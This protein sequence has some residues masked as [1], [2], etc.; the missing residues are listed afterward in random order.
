VTLIARQNGLVP[1]KFNRLKAIQAVAFLLKQKH[2]TKTDNYMRVLKLLYFA[3]R[4]S[5]KET[6]SPITGDHFVA[7]KHGPTL[8]QL[9]DLVKQRGV[10]N[11]EWDKY[12]ER[13]GYDIRLINDPGNGKLCRYEIDLLKRIWE[14][15]RE[16]G[17]FDVA[18][19]SEQLPEWKKNNP[20]GGSRPIPLSD[21]LEAIG[22]R[23]WL[24]VIVERAAEDRAA[25]H[26]F[27][28]G[29]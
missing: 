19:K 14:E 23:D 27:G 16:L 3:D 7:M 25:R 20:G 24:D 22:R 28:A 29:G 17:E 12:I 4:E 26:L 18:T 5:L 21:L 8:S 1:F 6:G 13:D 2:A 11:D 9:V 15:N 10:G